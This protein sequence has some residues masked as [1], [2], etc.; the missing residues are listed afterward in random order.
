MVVIDS[1][2]FCLIAHPWKLPARPPHNQSA[3]TK[4]RSSDRSNDKF[5]FERS[6]FK[7]YIC[8][9]YFVKDIPVLDLD[10]PCI[11]RGKAMYY[12]YPQVPRQSLTE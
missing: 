2:S 10:D 6:G 5:L 3:E 8:I 1:L 11:Y 9:F 4:S 7:T 12:R